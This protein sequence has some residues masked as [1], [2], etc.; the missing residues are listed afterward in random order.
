VVVGSKRGQFEKGNMQSE[1]SPAYWNRCRYFFL[2]GHNSRFIYETAVEK[3][4][5]LVPRILAACENVPCYGT[6]L[7]EV[8]VEMPSAFLPSPLGS[9]SHPFHPH[10]G[11]VVSNLEGL[12]R[13][14]LLCDRTLSV[15]YLNSV[16]D[17]DFAIMF[18]W[19]LWVVHKVLGS[20][21]G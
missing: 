17:F 20:V 1:M 18:R 5:Y 21:V 13:A 4:E 9:L 7:P 3:E 10:G 16:S 11:S 6:R 12:G 2:W 8:F 15:T 14:T 19:R